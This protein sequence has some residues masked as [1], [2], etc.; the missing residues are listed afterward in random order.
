[1]IL[2]TP[3]R[4]G[5]AAATVAVVLLVALAWIPAVDRPAREYVDASLGQ[6]LAVFTT[7]RAINAGLSVLQGTEVDAS[8]LGIGLT[9]AVGEVLDPANDLIERFSW[10]VL[11]SVASLGVQQLL[12]GAAGHALLAGLVTGTGLLLA[13]LLLAGAGGG[14]TRWALRLFLLAVLLRFA[15]PIAGVLSAG[16]DRLFLAEQFAV[17]AAELDGAGAALEEN[18]SRLEGPPENLSQRLRR[19]LP[20]GSSEDWIADMG[21]YAGRI[22]DS[23]SRLIALF[24]LKTLLLPLAFIWGF[25]RALKGLAAPRGG[26]S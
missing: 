17:S 15:M 25:A 16:A 9:L 2:D 10:V 4:R 22:V 14:G 26:Y 20:G 8:P 19:W 12:A 21:D 23:V 6:A 3:G 7:A 13:A 11:A 5:R 1:M 24:V 18:L